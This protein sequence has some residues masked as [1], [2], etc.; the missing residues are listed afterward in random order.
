MAVNSWNQSGTTWG[1]NAWGQQADVNLELTGISLTS[2]LGEVT[3]YHNSGWGRLTWGEYVWGA[4]YLNAEVDVTGLG[5]TTSLGDETAEG[6][7]EKG[8]GR[9]SWGIELGV[10]HIQFFQQDNH[11][12]LL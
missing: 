8:W 10:I 1:Q 9:G 12:L 7:I 5:L 11:L 2:S 4:D 6:T 3:A